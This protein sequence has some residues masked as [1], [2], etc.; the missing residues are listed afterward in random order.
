MHVNIL[1]TKHVVFGTKV[2]KSKYQN[3]HIFM[4]DRVL[5]E[6][7]SYKYVGIVLDP[8][9]KMNVHAQKAAQ[10]ANYRISLFRKIRHLLTKTAAHLVYTATILPQ[11]EFGS[12]I[13]N[14]ANKIILKD[15]QTSQNSALKCILR[16]PPLTS[17]KLIHK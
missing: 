15:I 4:G 1:K 5:E 6:V 10:T 12:L 11:I 9:L 7:L 13:Y 14:S 16:L 2:S 17:T 3:S 8:Y